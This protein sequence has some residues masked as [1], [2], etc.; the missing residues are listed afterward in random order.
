L[1]G[2]KKKVLEIPAPARVPQ[3]RDKGEEGGD[4]PF[5]APEGETLPGFGRKRRRK[6]RFGNPRKLGCRS[7]KNPTT[8]LQTG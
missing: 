5:A 2:K 3:P 4:R 8:A 6:T 7:K 1:I